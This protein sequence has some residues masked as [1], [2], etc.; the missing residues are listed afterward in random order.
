MTR[1]FT[2]SVLFTAAAFAVVGYVYAFEYDNLPAKVPTHWDVNGK[3]DGWTARENVFRT[4]LLM[5]CVMA[6]TVL[7][8]LVLPWLSP[9]PFSVDTFRDTYGY[10]MALAVALMG[11]IHVV[12]L[13]GSLQ[14][15]GGGLGKALIAGI[16]LFFALLGNQLGKVRRNFWMGVRTP[17]TLASEAVWDRTHRLA[18]WLYTAAGVV[19]FVAVL[20]DVP[21]IVCFIGL[22]AAALFPVPYSLVIYKR[23][24]RAGKLGAA[25]NETSE[26]NAT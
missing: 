21:M 24:E 8:A 10:I 14:A 2:L 23:L 11:Y 16:F 5:P 4:F 12:I 17:W 13:L 15:D 6:G 26:V 1:W 22:M 9:K 18:A 20:C 3:P 25:A 19:G 7:L